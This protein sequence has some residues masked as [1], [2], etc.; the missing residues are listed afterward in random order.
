M[1][2]IPRK[3]IIQGRYQQK[4]SEL[5]ALAQAAQT[6][7]SKAEKDLNTLKAEVV[8]AIRGESAFSQELLSDM[9]KR[10][11]EKCLQLS[12]HWQAAEASYQQSS[13]TMKELEKQ[14]DTIISMAEMYDGATL[15]ARKMIVSRIIQRVDVAK[16]YQLK[17][18]IYP[19]FQ[20]FFQQAESWTGQVA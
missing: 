6:E 13:I 7:F 18:T 1:Q 11:E 2:G 9:I 19:E 12:Q 20:A 14:Y 16:G 5:K 3:E 15:E 17:V 8:K 4:L 10:A